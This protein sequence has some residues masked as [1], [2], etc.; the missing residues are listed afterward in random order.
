MAGE[1]GK[2]PVELPL[3]ENL[4]KISLK[5]H[6]KR[7]VAGLRPVHSNW[8]G[9]LQRGD[10][11]GHEVPVEVEERAEGDAHQDVD[12]QHDQDDQHV[13]AD[14]GGQAEMA[15]VDDELVDEA[16]G[17]EDDEDDPEGAV[18]EEEEKVLVVVEAHAVV[19]PRAVV[20]HLQDAH[21]APG[22]VMTS[23]W[24]Q[25]PAMEAVLQHA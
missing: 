22:A 23:V 10:V 20:V 8:P 17:G 12:D 19:D 14:G 6:V 2:E 18:G 1:N 25:I 3:S 13:A 11:V 5:A 15:R 16:R 7:L 24:F 9:V 4:H 21:P